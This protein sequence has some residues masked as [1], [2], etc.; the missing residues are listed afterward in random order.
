[1]NPRFRSILSARFRTILSARFRT[2][3]SDLA[4]VLQALSGMMF[5]SI[6][7]PLIWR[8]YYAIPGLFVSGGLT[9][10]VGSLFSKVAGDAEEPAK[11]H[12]MMIAALGW[13][14]VALFGSLPFLLVA[15]TVYLDPFWLTIPTDTSTLTLAVFR[16]PLNGVFESM[17]GFTGTGLTMAVHED[18]LPH[19]LQWWRS[20]TQ[21]IGGVGVI[22]LT[23]AIL[24]RPG[25]GS[26]TL[27][28]SEARSAKI[29]P[30]IVSTVR[31]IWWIFLL[32]TFVSISLLWLVG[33]PL[34][35]AINHAMTGLS[36]GGF[37]VTDSSIASYDS[38][39]IEFAL[40]PVMILGSIA[41][42]VHYL[43]LQG[44]LRNLYRD[45]Q[46]RWVF[47]FFGSGTALLTAL[48]YHYG[49][50]ETLFQSFRY[51]LFQFVSAAS[52]TGFQTADTLSRTWSP[53][54][55]LTVSFGMFVGAAAGSTVGGIKLIRLLTLGKG[56]AY[57]ITGVFYPSSAIRRFE[58]DGRVLS[59]A[60]L[61]REFEE[62]AIITLLW[63]VFLAVGIVG[64][65]LLV[66]PEFT[67]VNIV[68]EIAS[69]QGNVGITTGITGPAMPT[70][71]KILLVFNMWIGRLEIIPVLVLLR[72]VLVRG[73][74]P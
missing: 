58:I 50:Y 17:S 48:L 49:T 56:T 26:L 42:P 64:L 67:L 34:W 63:L 60:E 24:S 10:G 35:D 44:D 11:L 41:F 74:R 8:E 46:T 29:H 15:W 30:S 52:C 38:V 19:T 39:V 61:S 7:V 4:R 59:D 40:V 5:L 69:T 12:G 54:S 71:A 72:A 53:V 21:W 70:L 33:M 73:D 22:V 9:L 32:F 47:V 55:K 68:F 65:S 31:T 25:S 13:L 2:I 45:L 51:A 62:A 37:S 57:R 23:T 43:V 1:M 16:N 66:S 36:T 28:E 3:L 20:F 14:L 6:L 27:Y 18:V